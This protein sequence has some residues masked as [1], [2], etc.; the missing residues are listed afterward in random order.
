MDQIYKVQKF[1]LFIHIHKGWFELNFFMAKKFIQINLGRFFKI[2]I[3]SNL[4]KVNYPPK[5]LD[6]ID[7]TS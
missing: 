5:K 3:Q 6:W 2:N 4:I 1:S 7:L